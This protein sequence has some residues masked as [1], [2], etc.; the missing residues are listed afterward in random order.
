MGQID[1]PN[2]CDVPF[3]VANKARRET[4]AVKVLKAIAEQRRLECPE[5]VA[6][7]IPAFIRFDEC[8]PPFIC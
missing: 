3:A 5:D 8:S 2:N 4:K 7:F 1:S 6:M